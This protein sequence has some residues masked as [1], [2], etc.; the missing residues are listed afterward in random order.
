MLIPT[1]V[2]A[3]SETDARDAAAQAFYK[4]TGIESNVNNFIQ[5]KLIPEKHK[6]LLGN[7]AVVIKTAATQKIEVKWSF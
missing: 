4:Q 1:L 7:I 6:E 3:S 5:N 2:Q